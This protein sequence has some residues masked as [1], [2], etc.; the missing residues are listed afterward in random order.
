MNKDI[1]GRDEGRGN[2]KDSGMVFICGAGPGNPK[3]LTLRALELIDESDVIL[4]DR[5]I[6]DEIIKLFPERTE[7]IYVGRNIGDPTTHQNKTNELMLE[8]AKKGKKVLRL[9]GGDPFI[10]GRGGEEA[11]YLIE[12]NINFEI[13]PGI[14]SGI[15]AA[16]YSGI[17]LTHRKYASSVVFVTGHEDPEKKT[18]IVKWEKLLE[19]SNTV[20][21]YMGTEKLDLII[22][23]ISNGNVDRKTKVAIVENGTLRNQRIITGELDNIVKKA[24]EE[25]IKPPSIVIIGDTVSLNSKINWYSKII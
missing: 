6:G 19:A 22:E 5:L 14:T 20:V 10:F 2:R 21:I 4:Y 8:Y 16:I 7:K 3:L 24:E 18:P 13:V 25:K 11:E 23:K 12:N 9:K 1:K 15:G 17:P